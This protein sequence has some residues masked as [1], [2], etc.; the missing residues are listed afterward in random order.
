M[1]LIKSQTCTVNVRL[2]ALSFKSPLP[3]PYET[4]GALTRAYF[5]ICFRQIS[6]YFYCNIFCPRIAFVRRV[7]VYFVLYMY[8]YVIAV[9]KHKLC[10][11]FTVKN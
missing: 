4:P 11:A 10:I 1:T 8:K 7:N 6:T 3:C 5:T 2:R 9:E